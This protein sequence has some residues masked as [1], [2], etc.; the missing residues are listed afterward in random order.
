MGMVSSPGLERILNWLPA[1]FAVLM[2]AGE[3]TD[4]HD[5]RSQHQPLAAADLGASLWFGDGEAVGVHSS[6]DSQD[7][8]FVGY[9]VVSLSFFYRWRSSLSMARH[10]LNAVRL[11]AVALAIFC[12]LLVASADEFHQSFLP[13]QTS[14]VYDVGIDV[15]GAIVMQ[16]VLLS[17]LRILAPSQ[18]MKVVAA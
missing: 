11:R 14:S 10:S 4:S 8:H 18:E 2:I 9:G 3:S 17:A 16:L 1:I 12:T 7:G 5:V 6:P 13:S 15:C